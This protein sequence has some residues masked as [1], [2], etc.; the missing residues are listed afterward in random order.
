[1]EP[2][3]N[4]EEN[5]VLE[6]ERQLAEVK[7]DLSYLSTAI[8]TGFLPDESDFHDKIIAQRALRA[9]NAH[10]AAKRAEQA[11]QR[12]AESQRQE[13]FGYLH[14]VPGRMPEFH[15]KGESHTEHMAPVYLSPIIPPTVEEAVKAE[16]KA[17][18]Y[19]D[20]EDAFNDFKVANADGDLLELSDLLCAGSLS[21]GQSMLIIDELIDHVGGKLVDAI[22]ERGEK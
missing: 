15:L 7:S 3:M 22:R 19:F 1:M 21:M 10:G 14:Y 6:L 9:S 16:R 20:F 8:G 18:M 11:E 5:A 13:P 17:L 12:I 2:E 4:D